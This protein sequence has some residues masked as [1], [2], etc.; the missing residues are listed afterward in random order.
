MTYYDITSKISKDMIVYK[1]KEEKRPK[2]EKVSAS[3]YETILTINLHTG[4]HI[5][6]PSHISL[7]G[8][9][10]SSF[11]LD[12][13]LTKVKVLDLTSIVSK[14]EKEDLQK[15]EISK[16][17]FILLKTKNSYDNVF[18]FDFVYLTANASKYLSNIG[19]SGVGIDCLGIEREQKDH[20]THKILFE[21]NIIILEGIN[22][23]SVPAGN[24][25]MIA[26]PLKIEGVDA[27]PIS[28]ILKPLA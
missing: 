7:E 6:F 28:A 11:L 22:L 20:A 24:Y 2:F 10:S 16:G 17:D 8:Q 18:N 1:N 9:N 25:D 26:M 5:D 3:T 21:N 27:L 23:A 19:I 15:F 12:R 13:L 14:I 4:T